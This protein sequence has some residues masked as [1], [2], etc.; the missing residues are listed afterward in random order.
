MATALTVDQYNQYI[1]GEQS[2]RKEGTWNVSKIVHMDSYETAQVLSDS[3][4]D[5]F[6]NELRSQSLYNESSNVDRLENSLKELKYAINKNALPEVVMEIVHV[7][8][9]PLLQNIYDLRLVK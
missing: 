1:H 5:I 6:T 3:I 9:H 2:N 4:I 7:Q 8:I